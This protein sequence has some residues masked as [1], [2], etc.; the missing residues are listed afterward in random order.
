MNDRVPRAS[1]KPGI[2]SEI[3]RDGLEALRREDADL[4]RLLE[5]ETTRQSSVLT[6]V[7][8]S[9]IA[10]PSVLACE[11]MALTNVTT[12]GYPGA[13]FHGGCEIVDQI[14]Q[15]A[16]ERA[17]SAFGA[18]YANV[19]PHS[20]SAANAIV[21]FSLLQ[22]GDTLMGMDLNAGGHLTHGS[23]ASVI[24]Q[25]FN[26]VAYG[27]NECGF[28]DYDQVRELARKHHPKL[29]ICGAS[30]YSRII[31][32]AAFRAIADEVGAV[33]LADIS[34]IAGLV[35]G[36]A[37]PSPIDHA[38]VTT[39]STY[40]QLYGPR[41]GLI[42]SGHDSSQQMPDGKG[43]LAGALQRA[44]F[45]FFQGTPNLSA[46]AAKARAL[47][48]VQRPE[49]QLLAQRI[50][51]N[52]QALASHLA[53]K[54]YDVLTGGSDNHT[55]LVDLRDKSMTG[56]VAERALEHCGVV[57]NKNRLPGDTKAARVTSGIRLGTN[58]LAHRFLEPADMSECAALID[59]VLGNICAISDREFELDETVVHSV[60]ERVQSICR[61]F[62]DSGFDPI[63][64]LE[65]VDET[66]AGR[67]ESAFVERSSSKG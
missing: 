23:K 49:F 46:I 66:R 12:E 39:T 5:L 44:V 30:A 3:S 10:E 9:S 36:G 47:A 55:V 50:V 37:H 19:Q 54:S 17:L 15:L 51:G 32:F 59:D 27:V 31:D 53:E 8:A 33:L 22:P 62:P 28:I 61:R 2:L 1:D 58:S 11:G 43:T 67:P 38:H 18:Q 20:G 64:T 21:I 57:V 24:G 4:Y 26:A 29:I 34:H 40:K 42:L 60:R 48:N 14:E 52:A 45:P 13:R 63:S 7:A 41:G 16:I 35:V 6:M 56:L 65:K 25:Y